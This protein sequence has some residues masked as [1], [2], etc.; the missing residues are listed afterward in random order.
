MDREEK[1]RWQEWEKETLKLAEAFKEVASDTFKFAP[2]TMKM[3]QLEKLKKRNVDDIRV[4]IPMHLHNRIEEKVVT[5]N[6]T[7][8][9][10]I[11]EALE[12][13]L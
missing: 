13:A 8:S 11:R 5:E 10:V 7:R 1:I 4:R 3:N 12:R 6:K 9:K 2:K